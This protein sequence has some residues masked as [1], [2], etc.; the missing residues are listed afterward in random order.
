MKSKLVFLLVIF[1]ST[2]WGHGGHGSHKLEEDH[3]HE[4]G[5]LILSEEMIKNGGLEIGV[6]SP[7][8]IMETL[9]L[10]GTIIPD[11][12]KYI[13]ISPRA[14]GIVLS[15]DYH[16][17]D[18]V[19]QGDVLAILESPELGEARGAY[20]IAKKNL[21][22][23]EKC[24]QREKTLF[25]KNLSIE[26][27][28]LK[29][30]IEREEAKIELAIREQALMRLGV[31][32]QEI[33]KM[34]SEITAD[35]FYYQLKAPIDG[36]VLER[37]IDLGSHL[38]SHDEAFTIGDLDHVWLEMSVSPKDMDRVE[39]GARIVIPL[40]S[41]D[42]LLTSLTKL[43]PSIDKNER[44]L[45]AMAPVDNHEAHLPLGTFI[46]ARLE[47]KPQAVSIAVPA[48]ALLK[49]DG[50]DT[51]FVVDG[52]H[53]EKR[54]VQLG[55]GDEKMREIISGLSLG[56]KYIKK[57]AHILKFELEKGEP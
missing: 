7:G 14:S 8:K 30:E 16:V 35:L 23:K 55:Q 15:T 3:P 39:K 6:A 2:L 27:D 19:R 21:A 36:L 33:E 47:H 31:N 17:G 49:M 51:L 25:Q 56:E 1:N 52:D 41:G 44:R 11:P 10:P 38:D 50:V 54:A 5:E 13:H 9:V 28:F 24:F 43:S 22:L 45:I 20:I 26:E 12:Q 34:G 48:V 42:S 4:D 53:L 18:P 37:H 57:N 29:R 46:S 32:S 40:K